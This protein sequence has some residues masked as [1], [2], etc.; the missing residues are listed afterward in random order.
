MADQN[1]ANPYTIF[2]PGAQNNL[3]GGLTHNSS[4][5]GIEPYDALTSAVT[6]PYRL[7]TIPS[8]GPFVG[9]CLMSYPAN[10]GPPPGYM[11]DYADP[12]A[13]I[14]LPWCIA[15]IDGIHDNLPHPGYYNPEGTE[16]E[17]FLF[18]SAIRAHMQTG[19]LFPKVEVEGYPL[20]MPGDRIVVTY[21]NART[22][23]SGKYEFPGAV[24]GPNGSWPRSGGSTGPGGRGGGSRSPL[25]GNFPS[26]SSNNASRP[27]EPFDPLSPI[28]PLSSCLEVVDV[29]AEMLDPPG[30][31]R[32][33][34]IERIDTI[35]LHQ[36]DSKAGP[37]DDDD[38]RHPEGQTDC[39]RYDTACLERGE[40]DATGMIIKRGRGTGGYRRWMGL[41]VHY[42]VTNEYGSE[43]WGGPKAYRL[44][45]FTK[46]VW[47]SHGFNTRAV[48]IEMEGKFPRRSD[49]LR[50]ER[51]PDRLSDRQAQV[52]IQ[53]IRCIIA[54]VAA[55][56]GRIQ[57][58]GAHRNAYNPKSGDPGFE[59]WQKVCIPIRDEFGLVEAPVLGNGR[60]IPPDWDPRNTDVPNDF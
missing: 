27:T 17:K 52:A 35:V 45:D 42:M 12:A 36:M 19:I 39:S 48:Q 33:N 37:L 5:V 31:R 53:L 47:G 8:N 26:N 28:P 22:F 4:V 58:I 6:A 51:Y 29:R 56:G 55:A 49:R 11:Y 50:P 34:P 25:G 54:E 9:Q 38:S 43:A 16:Q 32:D 44:Y 24:A 57:Y 3:V 18:W 30:S 15:R 40:R 1:Q 23:S 14:R 2:A 46:K 13:Q 60:P 41:H 59:T 20:P 21:S 10:I 7:P